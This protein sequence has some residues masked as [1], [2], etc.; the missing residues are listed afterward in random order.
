M[1]Y[2]IKS[3]C[4]TSFV[5]Q[6]KI[7]MGNLFSIPKSKKPRSSAAQTVTLCDPHRVPIKIQK[8]SDSFVQKGTVVPSEPKITAPATRMELLVASPEL[9]HDRQ[10]IIRCTWQTAGLTLEQGGVRLSTWKGQ[11]EAVTGY[12]NHR[13]SDYVGPQIRMKAHKKTLTDILLCSPLLKQSLFCEVDGCRIFRVLMSLTFDASIDTRIYAMASLIWLTKSVVR[14]K[15][16]WKYSSSY[17]NT[18]MRILRWMLWR[19]CRSRN[20]STISGR[21]TALHSVHSVVR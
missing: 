3:R 7:T 16:H 9:L 17:K 18:E 19:E 10:N 2:S 1:R 14:N 8:I 21:R 13:E 12:H 5:I 11:S 6:E 4:Q 15:I 20:T